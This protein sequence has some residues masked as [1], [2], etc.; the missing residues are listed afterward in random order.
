M[1]KENVKKFFI[2][3][4]QDETVK[5]NLLTVLEGI[6]P[7]MQNEAVEKI[8]QTAKDAGFE[9]DA[10]EL[11]EVRAELIDTANS[12]PELFDKNLDIVSGGYSHTI[13][14]KLS[15]VYEGAF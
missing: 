10:R 12:N 1:S 5:K 13:C 4:E 2:K 11:F 14:D 6:K 3:V 7:E 8:I 15:K 9:F